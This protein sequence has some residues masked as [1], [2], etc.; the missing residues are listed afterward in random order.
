M[1]IGESQRFNYSGTIQT[2]VVPKNGLYQLETFGAQGG[3][4]E[5]YVG[6]K[7]GFSQGYAMLKKGDTLYVCVGGYSVYGGYNGGGIGKP[8]ASY[9][10]CGGGGATHIANMTGVLKDVSKDALLIVAGGG[11]G[12]CIRANGASGGGLTGSGFSGD[13]AGGG[14]QTAGGRKGVW[15][16]AGTYG[17]G[18][19][20]D[21]TFNDI[22]GGGGGLYGGGGGYAGGAGGSGYIDGVPSVTYKGTTYSP[23]TENGK[24]TGNGY[25]IITFLA[26]AFPEIMLGD[27]ALEG[28]A[29]GDLDIEGIAIGDIELA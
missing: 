15:G 19:T 5:S 21:G 26:S 16:T 6:G 20:S 8:Y 1:N 14:S 12:C 17:Q 2:F 4:K 11:G 13:G 18:G 24:N 3:S 10:G 29:L 9:W 22:G 27:I 28:M 23:S 7:G 25:A